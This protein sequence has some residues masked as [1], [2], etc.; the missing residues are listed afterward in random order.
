LTKIDPEIAEQFAG[1]VERCGVSRNQVEI[2]YEDYLQ[3]EEIR[4]LSPSLTDTQIECLQ[5]IGLAA[6]YP[7]VTFVSEETDKRDRELSDIRYREE[8]L[9]WFRQRG[10]IDRLPVFDP[11]NEEPMQFAHRLERF[12]GIK[13]G[14]VFEMNEQLHVITLRRDWMGQ[15]MRK[16]WLWRKIH[17]ARLNQQFE[18]LMRAMSATNAA[19]HGLRLGFIGNEAYASEEPQE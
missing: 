15:S 16:G 14:T 13:P 12:C 17:G 19:E 10:L 6:P 9:E 2:S 1:A 4:V 11:E 5:K 7:I 18:C 8:S 3:S